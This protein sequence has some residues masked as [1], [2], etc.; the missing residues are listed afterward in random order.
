MIEAKTDTVVFLLGLL[1]CCSTA[2]ARTFESRPTGFAMQSVN[3]PSFLPF[4]AASV[5]EVPL[6]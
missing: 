2:T 4:G 1:G 5:R 3:R 6:N